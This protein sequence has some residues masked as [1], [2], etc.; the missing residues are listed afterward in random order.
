MPTATVR[1]G[2][3]ASDD[4]KWDAQR[5]A[6][7]TRS[8]STTQRRLR[9]SAAERRC[10]G[11]DGRPRKSSERHRFW[12]VIS[13]GKGSR[14]L[15]EER[16]GTFLRDSPLKFGKGFLVARKQVVLNYGRAG[17]I[18]HFEQPLGFVLKPNDRHST[19]TPSFFT[20]RE[21]PDWTILGSRSIIGASA[22]GVV[23]FDGAGACP[24]ATFRGYVRGV[25]EFTKC[26]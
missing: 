3:G 19:V 18:D 21:S 7:R 5:R 9:S 26:A 22:F 1:R 14:C 20:V 12:G 8:A 6:P 24:A 4:R 10:D 15:V 2:V 17:G 11:V 16:P 23:L 13:D 25:E